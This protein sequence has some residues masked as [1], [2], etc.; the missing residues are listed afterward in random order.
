MVSHGETFATNSSRFHLRVRSVVA[1]LS[2]QNGHSVAPR[3]D[4]SGKK[5]CH[6]FRCLCLIWQRKKLT[7]QKAT[8]ILGSSTK[9]PYKTHHFRRYSSIQKAPLFRWGVFFPSPWVARYQRSNAVSGRWLQPPTEAANRRRTWW[10]MGGQ[11]TYG[12]CR[13]LRWNYREIYGNCREIC[14]NCSETCGNLGKHN[15]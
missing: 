8:K 3:Q 5:T 11:F 10:T 12:N 4:A 13:L 14:G 15:T 2:T 9:T 1:Y 7:Q 6:N